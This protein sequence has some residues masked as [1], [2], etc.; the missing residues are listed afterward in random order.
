M[1]EWNH[2]YIEQI[3]RVSIK[4]ESAV[5]MTKCRIYTRS[6]VTCRLSIAT[7]SHLQTL[8]RLQLA[9]MWRLTTWSAT[10]VPNMHDYL[11]EHGGSAPRSRISSPTTRPDAGHAACHLCATI[12]TASGLFPSSWFVHNDSHHSRR[13]PNRASHPS[14]RGRQILTTDGWKR[15]SRAQHAVHRYRYGVS[16]T[17]RGRCVIRGP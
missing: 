5:Q 13:F 7:E 17:Q 10:L 2:T 12:L 8:E 14:G 15:Q 16:T 1:R 11:T 9:A 4:L 6:D 3:E